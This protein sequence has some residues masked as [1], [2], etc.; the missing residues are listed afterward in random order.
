MKSNTNIV[1]I[2]ISYTKHNNLYNNCW[3]ES[4]NFWVENPTYTQRVFSCQKNTTNCNI[5]SHL[6]NLSQG[7]LGILIV[8]FTVILFLHLEFILLVGIAVCILW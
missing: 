1:I 4:I 7:L 3:Q 5:V 6:V 2:N 8:A